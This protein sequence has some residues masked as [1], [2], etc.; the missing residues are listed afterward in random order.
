[1]ALLAVMLSARKL[2]LVA[3][4]KVHGL[5]LRKAELDFYILRYMCVS[6]IS[7]IMSGLGYVGIIKIKI[8]EHLEPPHTSWQVFLFYVS[9]AGMMALAIFNLCV[10][11]FL[12]VNAQGL[13]LQGPPNSVHRCV[14]ILRENWPLT[15][16]VLA[17]SMLC[18]LVSAVSI[19]WMKLDEQPVHPGPAIVCSVIVATVGLA[20]VLRMARL[21]SDLRI[22]SASLV[23][24][25]LTVAPLEQGQGRIDIISEGS[26][27]IPVAR[28]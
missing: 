20:A 12:I 13:T 11:G 28:T 22:E 10:S 17:C 24:G 14:E 5:D 21:A 8:P 18:L 3:G 23:Q 6:G 2:H 1:V 16:V 15:R 4:L 26:P 9:T 25:D 27:V 19:V 7:S